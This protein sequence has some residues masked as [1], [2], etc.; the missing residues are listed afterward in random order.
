MQLSMQK[1]PMD[2]GRKLEDTNLLRLSDGRLLAYAEY[3][4]PDGHPVILFHGNHNSRLMYGLIPGLPYQ[5][6]LHLIVPDRPGYGLSDFYPVNGSVVDYPKDVIELADSLGVDKFA[7]F[8]FSGG[9]P[10][11]LACAWKIPQRLVSAGV[12]GS[13]GPL[14]P[15]SAKGII[16][17]LRILYW[18]APRFPWTVR[19]PMA[20]VSFLVGNYLGLYMK[21]VYSQLIDV[22][23]AIHGRLGLSDALRSDRIEGFR[24]GGRA[25]SYDIAL[26]G[27]WPIPLEQINFEVRL[28]QGEE[29]RAVGSM[30]QYIAERLP[31]CKA[32]FIPNAGH[33]WLFDHLVEMLAA[34]VPPN[35]CRSD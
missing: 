12:F 27:R 31:D 3:G 32:T 15:A 22:D 29:D 6:G 9:G 23:Q 21:L 26:A 33:Y 18:L 19:I 10:A 7:V 1:H 34:L 16:P 25:S 5:N 11:V 28:W 14:T 30:G 24:Q 13:I 20:L 2:N 35:K 4:E 17:A 8:G